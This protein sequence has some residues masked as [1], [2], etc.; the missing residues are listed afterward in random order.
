MECQ[1]ITDNSGVPVSVV[2]P[3]STWEFIQKQLQQKL[4]KKSLHNLKEKVELLAT[5]YQDVKPF[6][7]ISDPLEWQ[8]DIRN[9]W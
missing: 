3:I 5:K 8:R 7:L 2:I 6:Q 4:K 9:E 1:Y